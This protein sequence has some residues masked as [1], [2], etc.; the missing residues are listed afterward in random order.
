MNIPFFL[1]GEI[2]S[3]QSGY[4]VAGLKPT[5]KNTGPTSAKVDQKIN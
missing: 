2:G 5:Q 3:N 4:Q 1:T